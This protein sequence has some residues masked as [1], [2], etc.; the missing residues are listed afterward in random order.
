MP[1]GRPKS[2]F[3]YNAYTNWPGCS[4]NNAVR[5]DK[6]NADGLTHAS[7][8]A[9]VD[10]SNDALS[11]TVTQSLIPSNVRADPNLPEVVRV[12][13]AMV[14]L[15]PRPEPSVTVVPLVSSNPHA[16]TGAV[17]G[18]GGLLTVKVT[19]TVFGEPDAPAAVMVSVPV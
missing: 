7:N 1:D 8:V 2:L 4:F 13:P 14:P 9:R 15:L 19:A 16:P 17:P 5:H 6:P 10:K 12:A 11:A 3:A 18:G